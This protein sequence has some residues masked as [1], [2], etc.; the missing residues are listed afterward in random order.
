MLQCKCLSCKGPACWTRV[1][2][3]E[4]SRN[5]PTPRVRSSQL[6]RARSALFNHESYMARRCTAALVPRALWLALVLWWQPYGLRS[7][8][9]HLAS[10]NSPQLAHNKGS[11]WAT[12]ISSQ[13][14][15]SHALSPPASAGGEHFEWANRDSCGQ[16][17]EKGRR[18][19]HSA[20]FGHGRGPA[21]VPPTCGGMS[22][23]SPVPH[24]TTRHWRDPARHYPITLHL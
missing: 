15:A 4:E 6:D 23:P 8:A 1:R 13:H 5:L 10:T 24:S 2:F 21:P 18:G 11:M 20:P 3:V 22:I 7:H 19:S 16:S 17:H 14:E 9:H 12:A